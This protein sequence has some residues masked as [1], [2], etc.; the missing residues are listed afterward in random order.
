MQTTT[1]GFVEPYQQIRPYTCGAAALKAVTKH[2]GEDFNEP[3]LIDLI[4]VDPKHG[5]SA[6]QVAGAARRLGYNAWPHEFES[7]DELQQYTDRDVPV[8]VAIRSFTR[9]GQGHFVVATDVDGDTVEFMDPNVKGNWRAISRDEMDSRWRFR[10]RVGVI[11]LPRDRHGLGQSTTRFNWVGW[12]P[13]IAI[14]GLIAATAATVAVVR[15]RRRTQTV[16]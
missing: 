6:E 5:S 1:L 15:Y 12:L 10:D 14:G 13:I 11:V 8:I 16:G 7:T 2:W 3:F 9:P 4:G